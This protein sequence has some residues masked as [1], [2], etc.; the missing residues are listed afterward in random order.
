MP[1]ILFQGKQLPIIH[2]D[3]NARLLFAAEQGNITEVQ[4]LLSKGTP[5]DY[6]GSAVSLSQLNASLIN[7]KCIFLTTHKN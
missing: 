1:V 7:Y 2:T 3:D 5:L 4:S 6:W